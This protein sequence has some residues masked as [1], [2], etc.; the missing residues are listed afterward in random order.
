MDYVLDWSARLAGDTIQSS[1]WT[2]DGS[3]TI[4]SDSHTETETTVWLSGGSAG[5]TTFLNRITTAGGR[6]MDQTVS[7]SVADK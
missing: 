1:T 3:V 2:P 7:L 5:K 4:D 6:T